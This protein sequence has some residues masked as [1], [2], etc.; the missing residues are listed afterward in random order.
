VRTISA[1]GGLVLLIVGIT[2]LMERLGPEFDTMAVLRNYWPVAVIAV[3]LPG[4]LRLATRPTAAIIGPLVVIAVGCA[5]LVLTLPPLRA[6]VL[7]WVLPIMLVV[8]GSGILLGLTRAR[9]E[10]T[11]E[12]LPRKLLVAE[13]TDIEWP[14]GVFTLGRLT[15]IASG[16]SIDL[17]RSEPM[18]DEGRLELTAVMSGLI[19][20]VPFGWHVNV[21]ERR[22][23]GRARQSTIGQ[24][25]AGKPEIEM[26]TLTI[27]GRVR[28]NH[29]QAANSA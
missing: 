9:T 29:A 13:S 2:V 10:R 6:A 3:G 11:G 17:G 21:E 8:T 15:A 19:V 7:P 20:N 12:L 14:H 4:T 16:H 22:L 25:S 27:F 23:F 28:V 1:L 18:N 26:Y 24:A 5:L